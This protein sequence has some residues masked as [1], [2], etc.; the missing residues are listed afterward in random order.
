MMRFGVKPKAVRSIAARVASRLSGPSGTLSRRKVVP[1]ATVSDSGPRE[2]KT[3]SVAPAPATLPVSRFVPRVG[4]PQ[5]AVPPAVSSAAVP[6]KTVRSVS[7]P[8]CVTYATPP[9]PV[10]S[11]AKVLF[12]PG[13]TRVH[14]PVPLCTANQIGTSGAQNV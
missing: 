11:N 2:T 6:K 1:P 12:A 14:A 13:C 8:L 4:L 9:R 3:T 10:T 5:A 7:P